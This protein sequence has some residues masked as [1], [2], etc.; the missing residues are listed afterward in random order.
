MNEQHG[1]DEIQDEDDGTSRG[2]EL[3]GPS[4]SML[5]ASLNEIVQL[6]DED[7]A[8]VVYEAGMADEQVLFSF[9]D[10]VGRTL[11]FVAKSFHGGDTE[12]ALVVDR[13]ARVC[14]GDTVPVQLIREAALGFMNRGEPMN[15]VRMNAARVALREVWPIS[16]A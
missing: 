4:F 5:L 8:R 1:E 12:F 9:L 2:E 15:L 3:Y 14:A 7:S 16:K 11:A 13:F 6:M 10:V